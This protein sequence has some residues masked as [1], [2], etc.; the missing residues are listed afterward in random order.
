[1]TLFIIVG[2][3]I[4][5]S[6]NPSAILMAS[7]ILGFSKQERKLTNLISYSLGMLLTEFSIGIF[8]VFGILTLI[9]SFLVKNAQILKINGFYHSSVLWWALLVASTIIFIILLKHSDK[10]NSITLID[11]LSKKRVDKK[12]YFFVLGIIMTFVE[13][14][15]A[16]PYLGAISLLISANIAALIKILYLLLY[17]FIYIFP[18]IL[19]IFLYIFKKD[20]INKLSKKYLERTFNSISNHIGTFFKILLEVIVALGFIVAAWHLV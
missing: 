1:M 4:L 14:S 8:A 12:Y 7:T 16:M 9:N 5:D 10:K 13:F 18:Q 15:T 6:L 20:L 11:K 19:I 17:A 3:A 2:L